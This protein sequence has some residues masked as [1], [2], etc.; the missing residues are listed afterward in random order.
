MNR[1]LRK[2]LREPRAFIRDAKA[3]RFLLQLEGAARRLVVARPWVVALGSF[4]LLAVVYWGLIASDRY[5]SVAHLVVERAEVSGGGPLDVGALLGGGGGARDLYLLR[6][7]LLSADMLEVLDRDLQLRA[8]YE[9]RE[10]DVFSR[11]SATA[12]REDYLEYYRARVHADINDMTGILEL[13]V[14]AYTPGMANAVALAIVKEGEQ[15]INAISQRMAS[16]QVRFIEG[17]AAEMSKRAEEA[18]RRVIEFQN[19]NRLASPQA[20]ME[21]LSAAISGMER[22]VSVLRAERIRMASYLSPTSPDIVQIDARIK[23]LEVQVASDR[24]RLAA[25]GG[26]KLNAVTEAYAS[27][28]RE[29]EFAVTLYRSAL[30][31]LEKARVDVTRKLKYVAILQRP[32]MPEEAQYPR[33]MYNLLSFAIVMMLLAGIFRL[34]QTVIREHRD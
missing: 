1:K 31:A 20:A 23:A 22:E 11:L 17:Q 30:T 24:A 3:K 13:K 21:S 15:Y 10:W 26:N 33:R 5:V 14:Q 32:T 9:S 7:F 28:Q 2:L 6:D 8:H 25:P 34:I 12:S 18:R 16:E 19:A 4:F 27:L 29:A